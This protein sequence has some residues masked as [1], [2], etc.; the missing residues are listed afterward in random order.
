MWRHHNYNKILDAA[1]GV[2]GICEIGTTGKGIGPAYEDKIGRRAIKLKDLF[3][4]PT[5][6]TKLARNLGE[7]EI[8]FKHRYDVAYPSVEEEAQRLF[9]LGKSIA[10]FVCDTFSV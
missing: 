7:K 5:L 2:S 9:S 10:P 3:D 4:L 1:R 8:L 6:K